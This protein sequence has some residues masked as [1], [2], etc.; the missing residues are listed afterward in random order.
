LSLEPARS[1]SARSR[2]AASS[3]IV[4]NCSIAS[5]GLGF[6]DFGRRLLGTTVSLLETLAGVSDRRGTDG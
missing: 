4:A 3:S 1:P 5:Y 6:G 2:T